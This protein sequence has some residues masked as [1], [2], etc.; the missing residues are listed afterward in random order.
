MLLAVFVGLWLGPGRPPGARV[1]PTGAATGFIQ[2]RCFCPTP[3]IAPSVIFTAPGYQV[4][5]GE[6]LAMRVAVTVPNHVRA[7]R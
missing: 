7:P 4:R 5:P 2:P 1:A 3:W 6:Y